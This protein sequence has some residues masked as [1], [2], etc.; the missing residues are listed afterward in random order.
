MT[1]HSTLAS[2]SSFGECLLKH[3]KSAGLSQ[4]ELARASG[5]SVR[6][7]RDLERGR[8][9]AAQERSAELLAA[10]LGLAGDE[11]STFLMLAQQ[12]RRRSAGNDGLAMLYSLPLVSELVGRQEEL[13]T[14]SAEAEHGGVVVISGPPG[15]GKTWLAVTA[16]EQLADRFPD[17]CLALNLRGVDDQ[18]MTPNAALERLL[19]ALGV[20]AIRTPVGEEQRGALFRMLLADRRILV[21]LDNAA[22]ESQVRPLLGTGENS[23]T[24]VTCRQVL[25]GL[26]AIRR[27]TLDVLP[28]DNAIDLITDITGEEVVRQD[29]AAALELAGLCG[30]LPLAVRIAGNRLATQTHSI[31]YLVRQLRDERQRLAALSAGD[32]Q[33]RSAFE[34]S[35]QRLSW[36]TRIVF[37]R[38]ALIPG[39]DFDEDL[40]AA[41][42]DVPRAKLGASLDELVDASLLT[43][44]SSPVRFQFHDLI[45]IFAQDHLIADEPEEERTRLRDAFHAHVLS[46][47]TAAGT[48]HLPTQREVP[49]DSPFSSQQEAEDWLQREA[50][51]WLAV[52][53]DAAA[54]EKHREVLDFGWVLH[55]YS[56]GRDLQQRWDEVFLRGLTAARALGD[57][58]TE[59]ELLNP[60]G[61]MQYRAANNAEAAVATLHGSIEFSEKIGHHRGEMV[62]H[63]TLGTLLNYL[64]RFDEGRHHTALAREMSPGYDFFDVRFWCLIGTPTAL[65]LQGKL[66]EALNVLRELL[67]EA[68]DRRDETNVDTAR[69]VNVLLLTLIGD[70]LSGLARWEEAAHAYR[71]A[72]DVSTTHQAGFRSDGELALAEGVAWRHAGHTDAAR[73]CLQLALNQLVSP[74]YRADRER[75]TAELALLAG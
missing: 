48:L 50:T 24:F 9:S 29:P 2:R 55:H 21:V 34:V 65:L 68:G 42:T 33:L 36:T 35:F 16:A 14:L 18:P 15:V 40:A 19:S 4:A 30:N 8:A 22:N 69:K 10:A 56:L 20:P 62:A 57:D 47:G 54:L 66:D 32:L 26:D 37:R 64:G 1:E 41:A 23:L 39:A 17:G 7:L 45:R 70:C 61:W 25:A 49:P 60:F 43:N 13:R 5:V 67:T 72:R 6:A 28:T 52:H 12:G 27:M 51:T 59:A 44:I 11:K 75:A 71:G 38:L 58:V 3:R 73:A 74:I 63:S 53:R 31:G 46:R